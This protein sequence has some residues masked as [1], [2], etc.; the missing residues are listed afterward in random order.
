M[1]CRTAT[2]RILKGPTVKLAV[3]A[4]ASEMRGCEAA[5][6][7]AAGLASDPQ[8]RTGETQLPGLLCCPEHPPCHLNS[9]D[10]K[11]RCASPRGSV[12]LGWWSCQSSN[13]DPTRVIEA[14][15]QIGKTGEYRRCTPGWP[16]L[17]QEQ[18]FDSMA[19]INYGVIRPCP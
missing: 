19:S 1:A 13:F 10:N 2:S 11:G 7:R 12:A 4:G 18:L 15:R 16:C 6:L 9:K 14:S 17:S 3:E 5:R 8:P